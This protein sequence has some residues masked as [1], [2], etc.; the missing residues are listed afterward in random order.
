MMPCGI[1]QERGGKFPEASVPKMFLSA[2]SFLPPVR[3]ISPV[4]LKA[5]IVGL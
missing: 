2:N 3:G 5:L 4:L 1:P